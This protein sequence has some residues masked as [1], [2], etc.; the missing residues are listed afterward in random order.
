MYLPEKQLPVV[1]PFSLHFSGDSWPEV[2][3]E[4]RVLDDGVHTPPLEGH[5]LLPVHSCS[6]RFC[7]FP[8]FLARQDRAQTGQGKG[9]LDRRKGCGC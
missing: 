2:L 8:T 7:G 4:L 9:R 3:Q 5:L 6:Q 1:G